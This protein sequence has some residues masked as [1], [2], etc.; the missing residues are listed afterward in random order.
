VWQ[1]PQDAFHAERH[2][3]RHLLEVPSVFHGYAEVCRYGGPRGTVPEAVRQEDEVAAFFKNFGWRRIVSAEVFAFPEAQ[4]EMN[5]LPNIDKFRK[6]AGELE[7][8]LANP[9]VYADQRRAG[10]LAR[11]LQH[12]QKL[13]GN[14]SAAEAVQKQMAENK[15]L[16]ESGDAEMAELA[17]GELDDLQRKLDML[18]RDVQLGLVPPDPN[19]SRNSIIEIRAGTG[20]DEAALFAGDLYRMYSRY[21]DTQRWKIEVMDASPSERGG[22]KEIVFSIQGQDVFKK[23]R[24]EMGVHRVQRV[25]ATEAQGR[26]HTSTAS[27]AVLPEA[28]EVDVQLRPEDMEITVCRASGPGGQGVNTTDSA[29][30]INHKPSGLIVR[31]ADER[32]QIKN[33]AKAL[34]VLRSRLLVHKQEEEAAKMTA[35]RRSQIGTADRSEKIRTYN[36]PQ[37]RVTDHRINITIQNLPAIVEGDLDGLIGALMDDDLTRRL[38]E[39]TG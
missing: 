14:Y 4:P 31:C 17:K 15:V 35:A 36:Y 10:E 12:L 37:N 7:A 30:Q 19:D 22:F 9:A 39:T 21:A 20:G 24:Y 3:Y 28:E 23:M 29:V 38:A 33:K 18:Y 13:V 16:I 8:E 5:A 1:H 25:P 11:E 34:R 26:I 27:V 6:R 2:A 32:S